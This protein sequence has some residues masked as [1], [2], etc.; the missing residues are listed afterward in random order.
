MSIS[1]NNLISM[2]KEYQSYKNSLFIAKDALN[3]VISQGTILYN[4]ANYSSQFPNNWASY[5]SY[6]VSLSNLINTF[7]ASV[8]A[9]PQLTS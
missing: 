4:D 8:P 1:I 3:N 6:L 9:E 2:S 7:L 5:Q